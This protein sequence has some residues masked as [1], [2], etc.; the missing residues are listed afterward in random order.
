MADCVKCG[1]EATYVSPDDLCTFHHCQWWVDGL[2]EDDAGKI[3]RNTKE[4]KKFFKAA[5]LIARKVRLSELQREKQA[6]RAVMSMR[7]S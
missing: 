6:K 7:P 5:K 4:Y 1:K 3:D 2:F